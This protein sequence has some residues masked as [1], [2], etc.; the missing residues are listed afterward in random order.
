M[1][2][3]KTSIALGNLVTLSEEQV[4]EMEQRAAWPLEPKVGDVHD[5]FVWDGGAWVTVE[6]WIARQTQTPAEG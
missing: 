1:A 6:V 4:R 3:T 5:G 2:F